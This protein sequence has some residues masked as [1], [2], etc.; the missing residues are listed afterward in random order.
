[1]RR[2]ANPK[3]MFICHRNQNFS[4]SQDEIND[5]PQITANGKLQFQ[6]MRVFDTIPPSPAKSFF[7]IEIDSKKKYIHKQMAF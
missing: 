6:G 5:T 4:F 2:M 3:M 1:M 7:C